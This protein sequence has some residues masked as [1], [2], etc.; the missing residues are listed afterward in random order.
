VLTVSEAASTVKIE[1]KGEGSGSR[2]V[3]A[4]W[5]DL[6][7]PSLGDLSAEGG[8]SSPLAPAKMFGPSAVHGET[9]ASEAPKL[10]YLSSREQE[11]DEAGFQSAG[12][13]G[14]TRQE[15]LG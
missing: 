15:R 9:D 1:Q 8:A 6:V 11:E 4:T 13:T 10:V 7:M 12:S 14:A 2:T 5:G 3:M